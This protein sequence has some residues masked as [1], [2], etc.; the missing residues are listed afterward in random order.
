L[1]N[2]LQLQ[3]STEKGKLVSL[4]D[5]KGEINGVIPEVHKRT[6]SGQFSYGRNWWARKKTIVKAILQALTPFI[7]FNLINSGSDEPLLQVPSQCIV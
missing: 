7:H 2:T 3:T 4:I 1:R 6:S 5:F